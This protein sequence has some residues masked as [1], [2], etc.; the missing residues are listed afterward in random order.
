MGLVHHTDGERERAD[1]PRFK[2]GTFSD[3]LMAEARESGWVVVDMK[4][5]WKVIYPFELNKIRS[6]F[7]SSC[8]ITQFSG[9]KILSIR[10]T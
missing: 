8:N 9:Q 6:F 5:D 1:G 3:A 2:V 10:A 7:V 4:N